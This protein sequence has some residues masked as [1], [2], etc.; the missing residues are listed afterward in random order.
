MRGLVSRQGAKIRKARKGF[1]KSGF[2][3]LPGN[4]LYAIDALKQFTWL[5][6]DSS[7][8]LARQRSE[9]RSSK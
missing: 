5:M 6:V 2:I 9:R 4:R 7:A 3:K 1:S 8:S